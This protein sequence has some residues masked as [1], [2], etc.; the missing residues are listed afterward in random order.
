[1]Q[2]LDVI[3]VNIW[4]ILISL[5]NLLIIFLLF[6]KFLY[7]RVRRFVD[8]RKANVDAQ[9]ERAQEAE[10]AA[11][12]DKKTYEDKL[13]TVKAETDEMIKDATVRA[14]R[15]SEKIITDAK[16]KADGMIRQSQSE[17]EL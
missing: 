14:D 16:E 12:A 6:K 13:Q 1:M 4:Q 5:C 10:N 8:K 17:I 15:R 7:A 9:Y 11:L 3:S 2:N